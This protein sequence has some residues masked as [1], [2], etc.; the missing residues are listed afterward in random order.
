MIWNAAAPTRGC[1]SLT[2]VHRLTVVSTVLVALWCS[3]AGAR[4]DS[5]RRQA[6][7]HYEQAEAYMRT[8]TYDKAIEEYQAAFDLT[9]KAGFL[10]N[11]G[12]AYEKWGKDAEAV[13]HYDKYLEAQPSGQASV[14]ARARVEALRKKLADKEHEAREVAERAARLKELGQKAEAARRKKNWTQAV[15]AYEESYTLSKDATFLFDIAKTY[16]QAHQ[17]PE[18]LASYERYRKVAPGGPQAAQAERRIAELGAQL[19]AQKRIT[20]GPDVTGSGAEHSGQGSKSKRS[21]IKWGWVAVGAAALA[22]GV[23]LDTQ[24]SSAKNGELDA[25]DF[26]PV[27]LYG[28]AGFFVFTGVF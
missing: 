11:I 25:L 1:V 22:A 12:L 18:A 28:A 10:F 3:P 13:E 24:P 20:S 9:G 17:L 21:G 16:E 7:K 14:E 6:E 2:R 8:S 23:Y 27:G 5:K 26:A 15:A 4:G 19:D